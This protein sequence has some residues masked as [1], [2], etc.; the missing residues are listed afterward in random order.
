MPMPLRRHGVNAGAREKPADDKPTVKIPAQD[1]RRAKARADDPTQRMPARQDEPALIP[2]APAE[3]PASELSAHDRLLR[4]ARE[5]FATEGYEN[6]TTAAIARQAGTSES[7]L[8]KHFG[9]KEGL[10]EAI[11]DEAWTGLETAAR[12]VVEEQTSPV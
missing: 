4:S 5:R 7:Q 8:V 6:A 9:S 11:F 1:P 2:P 3:P 10:L 12:S